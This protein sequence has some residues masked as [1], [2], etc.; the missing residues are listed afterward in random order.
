LVFRTAQSLNK[1]Y[2]APFLWTER[3]AMSRA[4]GW[5][6]SG[7]LVAKTLSARRGYDKPMAQIPLGVDVQAFRPD[8]EAGRTVLRKLRW[9]RGVPVVGYL[10]RFV[11]DKGLDLLTRAVDQLNCDWRAMFVG[12][13]PMEAQL[14]QWATKHSDRVRLCTDVM[15]D[16][17]PA[18][19]N[20]MTVL[21]GP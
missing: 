6:C 18:Y 1:P 21:C 8:D 15:H 4:A 19:L 2:P 12:T 9:K 14:R 11:P 3:Y 16:H 5:I 13:G 7:S 10:G 20:A 17:V